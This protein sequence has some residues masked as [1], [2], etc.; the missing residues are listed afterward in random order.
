M[1]LMHA[2]LAVTHLLDCFMQALLA[3]SGLEGQLQ[4]FFL[5]WVCMNGDHGSWC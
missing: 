3:D 4:M 5:P 1:Q 2:E